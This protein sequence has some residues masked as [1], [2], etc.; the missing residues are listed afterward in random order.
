MNSF[1]VLVNIINAFKIML[2]NSDET[3]QDVRMIDYVDSSVNDP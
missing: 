2:N 3:I 1:V